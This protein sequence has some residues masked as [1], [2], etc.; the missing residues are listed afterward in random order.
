MI[1]INAPRENK[2]QATKA[3]I[4][5]GNS[6]SLLKHMC[7]DDDD[8]DDDDELDRV[9]SASGTLSSLELKIFSVKSEI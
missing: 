7:N 9:T 4:Y 1:T 3:T 2:R 6:R 8:D 5:I